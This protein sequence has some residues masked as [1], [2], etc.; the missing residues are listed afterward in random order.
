MPG[1]AKAD[2]TWNSVRSTREN[3]GTGSRRPHRGEGMTEPRFHPE[4]LLSQLQNRDHFGTVI[5]SGSESH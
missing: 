1:I 5:G 4:E 3:V 2:L